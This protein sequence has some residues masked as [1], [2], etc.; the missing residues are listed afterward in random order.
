MTSIFDPKHKHYAVHKAYIDGCFASP[1]DLPVVELRHDSPHN[2]HAVTNPN[3]DNERFYYRI[4][5]KIITRTVSYPKP[6]MSFPREKIY[7]VVG[8]STAH[9]VPIKYPNQYDNSLKN[10]MCFATE[11][12]A[13]A[14]H[15]AL[16]GTQE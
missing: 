14:C 7:W 16:F 3:W 10:G 1:N 5:P 12:D 4:K 2:W 13:L 8:S 6:L 9:P 15:K 11:E